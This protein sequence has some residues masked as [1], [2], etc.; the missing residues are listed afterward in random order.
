[1]YVFNVVLMLVMVVIFILVSFVKSFNY[2]TNVMNSFWF[3]ISMSLLFISGIISILMAAGLN[4]D[5]IG[6]KDRLMSCN[7]GSVDDVQEKSL[8]KRKLCQNTFI[9]YNI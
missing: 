6:G 8:S 7:Y 9:S 3:S 5:N 2:H 1:M 4:M